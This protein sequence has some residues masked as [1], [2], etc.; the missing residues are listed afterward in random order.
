MRSGNGQSVLYL[1]FGS[2]SII[3]VLVRKFDE[4]YPDRTLPSSAGFMFPREMNC[5]RNASIET[6]WYTARVRSLSNRSL[7]FII[8]KEF[9][10]ISNISFRDNGI[11]ADTPF[12]EYTNCD[13]LYLSFELM[14]ETSRGCAYNCA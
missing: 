5:C 2:L 11:L 6:F 4:S 1:C 3:I 10:D 9:K 12:R 13:H 14:F 8:K 7:C